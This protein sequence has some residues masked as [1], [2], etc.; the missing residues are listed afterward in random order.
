MADLDSL[1]DQPG[2]RQDPLAQVEA[3]TT[4]ARNWAGAMVRAALLQVPLVDTSGINGHWVVAYAES[5]RPPVETPHAVVD[6]QQETVPRTIIVQATIP[7][8]PEFTAVCRQVWNLQSGD[9]M[10]GICT[11]RFTVLS[12][13]PYDRNW[14]FIC[15]F[16]DGSMQA[17]L[18]ES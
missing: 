1:Q 7:G 6:P 9:W 15:R 3:A 2:Q 8:I 14:E 12:H 4:A 13:F 16:S 5:D 11:I 10:S 17:L 18:V